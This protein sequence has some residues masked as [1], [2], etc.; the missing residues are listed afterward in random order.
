MQELKYK[1]CKNPDCENTFPQYT[2]FKKYCSYSCEKKCEPP[3]KETYRDP[4]KKKPDRRFSK[5]IKPIQTPKVITRE[6]FES[7]RIPDQKRV[8]ASQEAKV[9]LLILNR[10]KRN[11][12]KDVTGRLITEVHHCWHKN[13]GGSLPYWYYFQ[14]ENLIPVSRETHYSLHNK[15]KEDL[16]VQ[17]LVI[18]CEA[19]CKK[20][21]CKEDHKN[22]LNI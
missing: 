12:A 14:K 20:E 18:F 21:E 3:K 1:T 6:W 13:I 22:Y 17:E 11:R 9:R 15:V 10:L 2:S 4:N 19:E 8:A 5:D 16:T 7:L